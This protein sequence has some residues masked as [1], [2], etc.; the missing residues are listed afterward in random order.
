M[1]GCKR[2]REEDEGGVCVSAVSRDTFTFTG[3]AHIQGVMCDT[4]VAVHCLKCHEGF[5][6][7]N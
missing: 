2:N 7:Q 4:V 6:L 5:F 1:T 3:K